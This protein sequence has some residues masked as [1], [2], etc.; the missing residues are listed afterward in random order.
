MPSNVSIS[1]DQ[2]VSLELFYVDGTDMMWRNLMVQIPLLTRLVYYPS[3]A[4]GTISAD[5][6]SQIIQNLPSLN[7]IDIPA[8]SIS[9]NAVIQFLRSWPPTSQLQRFILR[10]R[11]D[12]ELK[13]YQSVIGGDLVQT[14]VRTNLKVGSFFK[15]VLGRKMT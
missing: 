14:F 3:V 11:E 10:A 5:D 7:E 8:R 1:F 9:R 13:D 15:L 12:E 2:L 4:F 6:V